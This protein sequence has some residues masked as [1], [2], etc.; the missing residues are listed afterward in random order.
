MK[1]AGKGKERREERRCY[2]GRM[3]EIG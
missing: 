2:K 3:R 1:E